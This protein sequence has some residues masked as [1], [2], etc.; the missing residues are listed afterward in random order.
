MGQL[1]LPA[2]E[3]ASGHDPGRQGAQARQEQGKGLRPG[4]RAS[5]STVVLKGWGRRYKVGKL[6]GTILAFIYLFIYLLSF[7]CGI[8]SPQAR[9]RIGSVAAG[10]HRRHSNVGS[11]PWLRPT[12]QLTAT[13]DP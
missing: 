8:R 12:P 9:G 1:W 11:E 5:P 2:E 13:S 6:D 4:A 10:L 3:G 7:F